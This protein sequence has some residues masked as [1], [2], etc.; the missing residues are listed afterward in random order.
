MIIIG[1]SL[2][3]Q[4]EMVNCLV[5]LSY[6]PLLRILINSHVIK[7]FAKAYR[8]CS[9]TSTRFYK[10]VRR[11]QMRSQSVARMKY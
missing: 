11:A 2:S 5:R 3:L 1:T 10:L 7:G 4:L 6:R 9:E 8:Y